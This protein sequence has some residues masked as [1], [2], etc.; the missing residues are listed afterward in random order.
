MTPA[1]PPGCDGPTCVICSDQATVAEIVRA[2]AQ[3]FEDALVRTAAGVDAVDVSLV[4]QVAVG[5]LVLVH[6]GAA[7]GRVGCQTP[8]D[9][10]PRGGGD[11]A[12]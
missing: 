6:A 10:R 11:R 3:V 9:D 7:I 5:D 8:D 1:E 2:P 12:A 4:G